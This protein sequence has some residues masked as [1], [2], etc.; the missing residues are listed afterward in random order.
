MK[1]ATTLSRRL[2]DAGRLDAAY[3]LASAG[4]IRS[5]LQKG[6]G[7]TLRSIDSLGEAYAPSRFKRTYAVDGEQSVPYLRPY[8]VFEYLPPEAD[9][10]SA[11]RTDNLDNYLI[12]DGD[13]LQTCS[14]RNLGPV[15]IADSYLT[16][17]V[18]SHDMIRVRIHDDSDRFYVLAFLR[19]RTGQH[20]LRGDRGGSVISHITTGHVE[21]LHVPFV[22][23]IKDEVVD[24]AM[25]ATSLRES[26]RI[27]LHDAVETIDETYPATEQRPVEGWSASSQQLRDRF[28]SAYHLEAISD[29]R[30]NLTQAGGIRL[31]DVATIVK[32]GGRYKMVYVNPGHGHPFLSGRQ[33][34]QADVVAPK[35]LSPHSAQAAGGFA[36]QQDSV[37]FQSDGRAEEGLGYPAYVTPERDGWLASGHVGRALPHDPSDAGWIWA[38]MASNVVRS[39]VVALSTG[40]VVDALYPDDVAN[41]LLPPR[42]VVDSD[43]IRAAWNRMAEGSQLLE[44]ASAMIDD[45]LGTID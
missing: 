20:L 2:A 39:Q 26:A 14:G 3:F 7:H 24:L 4:A 32:P 21:A 8:D 28:D 27:E 11:T 25:R 40:S 36:L 5:S 43:A 15:T 29:D 17:F 35:N 37:I 18:L 42:D 41:V 13:I 10:L 16:Q 1:T 38:S 19:S 23:A 9:R 30:H 45:T 31:G 34:L 44:E 22:H 33:I 6:T 12:R